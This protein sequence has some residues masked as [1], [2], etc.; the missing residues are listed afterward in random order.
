MAFGMMVNTPRAKGRGW[1]GWSAGES[2]SASYLAG[3]KQ[4]LSVFQNPNSPLYAGTRPAATGSAAVSTAGG[5]GNPTANVGG[6]TAPNAAWDPVTLG[7][8]ANQQN[9][10]L[11]NAAIAGGNTLMNDVSNFNTYT[12]N[13][14]GGLASQFGQNYQ[15]MLDTLAGAGAQEAEDIKNAYGAQKATTLGGLNQ[16]GLGGTTVGSSMSQGLTT[17]EMADQ[18]RL[19]ERLRQ[20]KLGLQEYGANTQN[21]LGMFGQH[22]ADIGAQMGL[23]LG[24]QN[25][26]RLTSFNINGQN[27][28]DVYRM[29]MG[30]GKQGFTGAGGAG[31]SNWRERFGKAELGGSYTDNGPGLGVVRPF[32]SASPGLKDQHAPETR[33]AG[34]LGPIPTKALTLR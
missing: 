3:A 11:G 33:W 8:W 27:A 28:M 25:V 19:Q 34:E 15:G 20:Q 7:N 22:E 9:A 32:A 18:G 1:A 30:L 4:P 24:E 6:L 10:N 21:Q 5:V 17:Q 12:K 29:G 31:Q 26:N 2:G 16:M 14:M 23:G 13:Q